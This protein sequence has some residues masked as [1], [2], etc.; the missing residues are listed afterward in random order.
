MNIDILMTHFV[1]LGPWFFFLGAMVEALPFIGTFL[2]GA[3]IVTL[4]GFA[5]A[6]G[7]FP[8]TS[9]IIFSVTGAIVGDALSYYIGSHG[10]TY[11]RRKKLIKDSLFQKG[12][13]FFH[14]YGNQSL[15]WGRFIGPIRSVMPFLAG[16]SKLKQKTFWIWNI[17]SGVAWGIAYVLLGYFSGNLFAVILKR[18]SHRLAWLVILS[19]IIP[20]LIWFNK[21][22][23]ES[24]KQYFRNQSNSFANRVENY[25]FI[26]NLEKHYPALNE[27]FISKSSKL[28]L[29]FSFVG[30]LLLTVTAIIALIFDLF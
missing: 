30:F 28:K 14:K 7:Y 11:L 21:H 12:E 22:H 20:I 29:Y 24:V 27:F 8:L 16:L 4:G 2:P 10:G 18:W 15:L 23:G 17:I 13:D 26:K 1:W 6:Q 5:A 19:T 3:T 9:V 25:S